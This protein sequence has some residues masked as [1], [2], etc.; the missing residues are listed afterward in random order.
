MVGVVPGNQNHLLPF[1]NLPSSPNPLL[2]SHLSMLGRGTLY[3]TKP[4]QIGGG[5]DADTLTLPIRYGIIP[6]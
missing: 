6:T 1:F 5:S 2:S 4:T 3:L